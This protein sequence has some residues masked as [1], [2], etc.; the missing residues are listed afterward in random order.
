[1]KTL[2]LNGSPRKDGNT[3]ALI[4]ELKKDLRGDVVEIPVFYSKIAPCND[5]RMCWK[6][7]SC[8]IED[9]MAQIYAD[10]FDRVVIA[11]PVFM[12]NLP[13]PL[14]G[15]ASRF[16]VYYAATNM[17]KEKIHR[18]EKEA[19]LLLVG[20]GGGAPDCAIELVK[21]MCRAMKAK[22]HLENVVKSLNT[23]KV[24]A[25]AD[26]AALAQVREIVRRWNGEG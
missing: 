23:D 11:S 7:P 25:S 5:C 12:S 13:S 15:L 9:D 1:M 8:V 19:A 4:A 17:L 6:Q 20:G 22:L 16:Q 26:Q 21:L 3:S 14:V 18:C 10:D 24:P 2:I